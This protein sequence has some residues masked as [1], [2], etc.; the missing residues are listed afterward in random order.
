MRCGSRRGSQ[1]SLPSGENVRSLI[2]EHRWT[3]R[4]LHAKNWRVFFFLV[5]LICFLFFVFVLFCC[6]SWH[7][8]TAY[9]R[10]PRKFTVTA[11]RADTRIARGSLWP[12]VVTVYSFRSYFVPV[13][14]K[15]SQ[16]IRDKYACVLDD[17][18]RALRRIPICRDSCARMLINIYL[19]CFWL[20]INVFTFRTLLISAIRIVVWF[21]DINNM[22]LILRF[23][24]IRL[25]QDTSIS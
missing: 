17:R 15:K 20:G 2:G 22:Y 5:V 23:A 1:V 16:S 18:K 9:K 12:F 21:V 24:L 13:A 10:V 7:A 8:D 3:W 19:R 25:M 6:V 4:L 14:L 11:D